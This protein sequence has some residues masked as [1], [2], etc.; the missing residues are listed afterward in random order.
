MGYL[1]KYIENLKSRGDEDI[2]DSVNDTAND[3]AIDYLD[4]FT[5]TEHEVGLLFG[6][7]QAGKTGQMLGILCAAA[8]RSFP[9]FIVLTTD[10]VALQKQTYDRIVKDLA[11]CEFCICGESDIQKFI[12]NALVQPAVIVLKKNSKVLLQWSNALASSSFV[13]GNALLVIDD[14]ADAASLNTL[15]NSNRVS[16]INKR[17][18]SIRDAS[19]GSIYLQVTGTPQAVFLQTSISGFKP[20]FTK[21][22]KP[23]KNYLGGDFFFGDDKK[24]IRFI[25]ENNSADDDEADDMFDA[26]IHHLVCSAQSNLV[27][28]KVCNFVIHPGVRKE[29]HSNAKKQIRNIISKCIDIKDSI[30]YEE[31][32]K[33]EYD[34]LNPVNSIKQP[35]NLLLNKTKEILESEELKILVMNGSHATVEDTE[36]KS[37]Y[38]IIIGGNIL[39][40]G[41][42]FHK[43]QTIYYTRV[44]KKP[45]ADTMWQHSRMFGYDRDA[46][47]MAVFITEHLYKL[48]MDIN[49][50]NNSMIRQIEKGIENIQIIY[51]E[52]INPTRK[53]VIDNRSISLLTGGSNYYADN[54]SNDSIEAITTML[55]PFDGET[56]SQVGLIFINQLLSHIIPSDDFNLKGFISVIKAQLANNPA[57]QGIL[58]VR[59]NREVTQGT[60]SLLSPNDR[61]LGE[62][63]NDKVV[64]TM[65]QISG[66]HG[67]AQ[68]N[69]W[70]PNIKLPGNLNYY[71]I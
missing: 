4:K 58:I 20:A 37:G 32:I 7:V 50:G 41:V 55:S 19:I 29:S 12:D 14:E 62:Q 16:T 33:N 67:W 21:F 24:S 15:V 54:P 63:F 10:N 59:K 40:R 44:A 56:Y 53:N 64:L 5:F 39:G 3:F 71:D 35:F 2:A 22:F 27:N 38:N 51:P 26:F 8:D 13:K 9:V 42:T 57:S 65:Y 48:F 45:Q 6:N 66:N 43:L 34:R 17:I 68:E 61:E 70:V 36:Y 60:G 31:I 30:E 18:A 28:K 11:P 47:M 23:G 69:V 1:E 52:G 49:E 25:N 46:G